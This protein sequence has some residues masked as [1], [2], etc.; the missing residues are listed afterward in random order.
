MQPIVV[1]LDMGHYVVGMVAGQSHFDVSGSGAP[2]PV[3][4]A[5][6]P[7]NLKRLNIIFPERRKIYLKVVFGLSPSVHF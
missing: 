5:T 7:L 2:K 3:A 1:L 4:T 6:A